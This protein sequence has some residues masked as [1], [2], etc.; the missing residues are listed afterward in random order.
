MTKPAITKR[1]TKGSVL[2]YEELDQNFQNLDDATI[3]LKAGTGGTNVVSD[4]NGTITLVAGSGITLAGDNTAKTL[5]ITAAESQNLFLNVVAGGTT[6]QADSTTDTL[7]LTGGTGISVTGNASTDTATFALADTA[8]TAGTYTNANVTIDAQGRI[9]SASSGSSGTTTGNI[10]WTYTG[11]PSYINTLNAQV[12]AND[13]LRIESS[14]I[15]LTAASGIALSPGG[16]VVGVDGNINSSRTPG[17][18]NI[19]GSTPTGA[20]TYNNNAYVDFNN[21]SGIIIVNRQD[22]SSGN[23][24]VWICGGG[25]AVKLGDSHGNESGSVASNGVGNGY[26]WTN[27]T[28]GTVTV[29]FFSIQTRGGA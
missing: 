16:G 5:T 10:Q 27:N 3:T 11:S 23:V 20:Y 13:S 15:R 8:V 28:G 22:A 19:I 9:T 17:Q 7:T 18:S 26:R 2:T 21:F 25:T 4:L 24:A 29:N 1:I 6:L 12:N 14:A